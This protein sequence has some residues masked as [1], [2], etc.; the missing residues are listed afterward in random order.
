M[1]DAADKLEEFGRAWRDADR[2]YSADVAAA[3]GDTAVIQQIERNW[4]THQANWAM[5]ATAALSKTNDVIQQLTAD[6][7]SLNDRI[8]KGREDAEKIAKI[9]KDSAKVGAA[10][11]KLLAAVA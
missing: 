10:L 8:E 9:V 4:W 7:K 5:A 1:S 2:N 3:K 11:T 6:A